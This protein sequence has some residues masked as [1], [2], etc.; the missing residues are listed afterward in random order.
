M[1]SQKIVT[2]VIDQMAVEKGEKRNGVYHLIVTTGE[3]MEPLGLKPSV[4][5]HRYIKGLVEMH[6]RGTTAETLGKGDGSQG[7]KLHIR[8][9]SK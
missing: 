2:Q 6:Y 9:W 1:A 5:H 7:F 8:I 4:P 3:L